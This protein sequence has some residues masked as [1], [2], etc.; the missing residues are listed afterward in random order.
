MYC[1]DMK[2]FLFTILFCPLRQAKA[3]LDPAMSKV[4]EALIKTETAQK[5]KKGGERYFYH[6][7]KNDFDLDKKD[8]ANA[9]AL[10][11]TAITGVIDTE[12]ILKVRIRT[13]GIDIY[14]K[15]QYYLRET[16][17]KV[18]VSFTIPIP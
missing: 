16:S 17:G 5:Y 6:H 4:A 18:E 9:G 1:V 2:T 8:L 12:R 13:N 14:P 15:V 11:Y 10:S 3:I 7:M